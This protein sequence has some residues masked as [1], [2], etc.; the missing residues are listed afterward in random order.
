MLKPTLI[1]AATLF[2]ALPASAL[3]PS[4]VPA[5]LKALKSAQVVEQVLAQQAYLQ[6]TTEQAAALDN[7]AQTIRAEKHTWV[8]V[9]GKQVPPR[10]V[11]RTSQQ[12]AFDQ[13]LAL[14]T[15]EQQVR[16]TGLFPAS[17]PA[18]RMVPTVRHRA[19]GK[20]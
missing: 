15:A 17:A 10:H 20:A 1:L 8:R 13:A 16:F 4:P 5:P 14:L 18:P 9:P 6:L 7:L 11:P 2:A 19:P 3:A 12:A